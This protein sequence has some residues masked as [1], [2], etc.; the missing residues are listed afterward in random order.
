MGVDF[1]RQRKRDPDSEPQEVVEFVGAVGRRCRLLRIARKLTLDDMAERAGC[2]RSTV[3][4]IESGSLSGRIGDLARILWV[5]DDRGLQRALADA[6][7]DPLYVEATEQA[8]PKL[9]RPSR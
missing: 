1:V 3:R 8:L 4:S 7:S 5:L 9:A 6:S 2:A